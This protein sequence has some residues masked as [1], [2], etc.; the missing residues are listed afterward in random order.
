VHIYRHRYKL[1]EIKEAYKKGDLWEG[2][3]QTIA[4]M[5][6]AH[7]WIW[8]SYQVEGFENIPDEGGALIVYYHGAIPLDY[9]YL[10]AKCILHKGRLIQAV[11]DRFLF[12][13][14]GELTMCTSTV[15]I[16]LFRLEAN[17][18]SI[19]RVPGD[20]SRLC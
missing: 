7:G 14:P 3:R 1:K 12:S 11:G 5:W 18:G 9:Y 10:L 17:D 4:V 2:C 16:V 19:S 20:S 15:L 8:H 13:I 6:D